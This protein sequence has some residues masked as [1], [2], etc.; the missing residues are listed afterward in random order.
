[1]RNRKA[2]WKGFMR[3]KAIL[4]VLLLCPGLAAD[5]LEK[6]QKKELESQVR[7]MTAEAERLER[8]GQL[9]EARTKYAESQALIEM[10]D[11][12]EALK[13]LDDEIHKR[14]KD[15]LSESRKLYESHKFQEAATALDNSMK[16]GAFQPLLAYDLALCYYQ[17]GQR[18]KA[19]EYLQ[20]AKTGTT[21]PKQKE[22]L[23]QLLTFFTTG[24]KRGL[25]G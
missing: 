18:G 15:T 11:V 21:E 2:S 19:L 4:V 7:T 16:L 13:R 20:K 25:G 23:L 3:T 14:V 10:K 9:A 12:T 5:N 24:E 6:T 17:L 1:M 22:K 8:T